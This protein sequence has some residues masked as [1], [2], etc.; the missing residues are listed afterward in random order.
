M[1]SERLVI[2]ASGLG[3]FFTFLPVLFGAVVASFAMKNIV[4]LGFQFTT[5]GAL[6][7]GIWLAGCGILVANGNKIEVTDSE[8]TTSSTATGS[9]L[10]PRFNKGTAKLG[11]IESVVLG[12]MGYFD[13]KADEFNDAK[14]REIIDFW[15]G[16]FVMKTSPLPTPSPIWLAVQKAPL[17][18]IRTKTKTDSLVISTK[19]FFSMQAFRQLIER[20]RAK[21]VTIHVEENLL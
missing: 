11:D 17:L 1:T 18:L 19:P 10:L 9:S 12:T 8:L 6:L 20:L 7:L 15:H 16:K 21:G 2:R 5:F 13:K 14:L 4:A 3:L